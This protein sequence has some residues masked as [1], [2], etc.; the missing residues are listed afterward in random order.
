MKK[1]SIYGYLFITPFFLVFVSLQIYPILKTFYYTFTNYKGYGEETWIGLAN[2]KAVIT[3]KFFWQAFVKTW[4]I[5]GVNIV[6]QLGL[7]L[8]LVMIF[9][10]ITWK[11]KGLG[12][13]RTIFYLPNLI[14]LASV[15]MLFT[16]LLDWKYGSLNQILLKLNIIDTEINY[17]VSEFY[18]QLSVSLIQAWMWFGNSFLFLMAGVTGISRDY[19]EAAKVDGANRLQMFSKVTIPLLKPILLYVAIT[20]LIGGMQIFEL[21]Y[22]LTNGIGAPNGSLST[23]VLY[24]FNKAFEYK[25][26][27]YG[28]TVAYMIFFITVFFSIIAFKWMY[29]GESAKGDA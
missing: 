20:S 27:G 16:I 17:L 19:F 1:R 15:A 6:V 4:K 25:Q 18:S 13:F 12:F 2:W 22:L 23:L 10:D 7:A 9:S 14:T 21:P 26:F 29:G 28:G 3:D 11:I 8:L 5:W 24:M